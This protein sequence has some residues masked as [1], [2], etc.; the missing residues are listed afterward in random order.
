MD[1][2]RVAGA[3]KFSDLQDYS[4]LLALAFGAHLRR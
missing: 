4:A 2:P 3:F 1:L